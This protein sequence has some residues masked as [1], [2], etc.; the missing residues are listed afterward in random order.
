MMITWKVDKGKLGEDEEEIVV[1]G[2]DDDDDRDDDEAEDFFI[3]SQ[4]SIRTFVNSFDLADFKSAKKG[5]ES[6]LK[7]KS[8]HAL[9]YYYY[10]ARL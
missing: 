8:E 9:P 1:G 2:A 6:I 5:E 10:G 3:C 7:R 4:N